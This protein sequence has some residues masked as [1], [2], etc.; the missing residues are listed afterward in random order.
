MVY[1]D[2]SN[3]DR[4]TLLHPKNIPMIFQPASQLPG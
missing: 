4:M 2:R 1:C 3:Y